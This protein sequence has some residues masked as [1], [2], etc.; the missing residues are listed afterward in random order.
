MGLLRSD[1]GH[2]VGD[3]GDLAPA[4]QRDLGLDL[5]ALVGVLEYRLVDRGRD[6]ARRDRHHPDAVRRQLLGHRLDEELHSALRRAVVAE[7]LPRDDLVNARDHHDRA[8]RVVGAHDARRLA[9]AQEGAGEVHVDH[10]L[11]LGEGHVDDMERLLDAGV[12]DEQ[13]EAA[14]RLARLREG[15]LHV[16]LDA[17]VHRD[18][19]RAPARR[20]D[21]RGHRAR[22]VDLAAVVDRHGGAVGGERERRALADAGGGAGDQRAAALEETRGGRVQM[23]AV[24]GHGHGLPD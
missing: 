7:A 18:G 17:D 9:R 16:G 6:R 21:G 3:V 23:E 20:L 5:A 2:G 15:A 24:I 12:V 8:V 19:H 22:V 14:E 10:L 11:P 13:I 1:P 4:A